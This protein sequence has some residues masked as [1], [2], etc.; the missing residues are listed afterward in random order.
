M[1]FLSDSIGTKYTEWG[2][3]DIVFISA[4]TGSGKTTFVLKTLLPYL[5]EQPD[6]ETKKV[7]YLV[8][9]TILKQQIKNEIMTLES[10]LRRLIHV[11]LYQ[12]IEN[13]IAK[14]VVKQNVSDYWKGYADAIQKA[15]S[16]D[17]QDNYIPQQRIN[18]ELN[19]V[20]NGYEGFYFLHEYAYVICDEAHY[21]LMDSNYNTR[22]Y[23]SYK[24]VKDFFQTK[25]RIYMSATI[26]PIMEYIKEDDKIE[27]RKF[28]TELLGFEI[29]NM[30]DFHRCSGRD[31]LIKS[32]EGRNYD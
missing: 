5:N 24:F 28:K 25:V 15:V 11:E 18:T 13:E 21:F 9:R 3:R 16:I 8:N 27:G 17:E 20:P 7:L 32:E 22:T 2:A 12:T 26:E 10:K 6:K 19:C 1:K 14:L 29:K 31:F 23:L 4:P 30:L